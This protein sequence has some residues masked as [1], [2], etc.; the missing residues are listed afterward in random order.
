MK[1]AHNFQ[2][3][4]MHFISTSVNLIHKSAASK[5]LIRIFLINFLSQLEDVG[6]KLKWRQFNFLEMNAILMIKLIIIKRLKER[7]STDK[8][9]IG[10]MKISIILR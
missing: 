5:I 10:L 6:S 2:R 1:L 4:K 3:F 9:V 7:N 8:E